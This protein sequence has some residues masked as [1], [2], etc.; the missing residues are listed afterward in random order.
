MTRRPLRRDWNGSFPDA[1]ECLSESS[2]YHEVGV[3][4]QLC[5]RA[6]ASVRVRTHA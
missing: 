3:K 2:E 4:L 1:T 5:D 6:C